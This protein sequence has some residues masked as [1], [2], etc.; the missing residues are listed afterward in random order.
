MLAE[1]D[2]WPATTIWESKLTRQEVASN[3]GEKCSHRRFE[4]DLSQQDEVVV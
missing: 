3:T 4:S 1:C 2:S